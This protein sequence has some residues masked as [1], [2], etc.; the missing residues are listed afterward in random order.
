M[1]VRFIAD[2]LDMEMDYSAQQVDYEEVDLEQADPE[3]QRWV[4]HSLNKEMTQIREYGQHTYI[5]ITRGAKTPAAMRSRST[6]F[7]TTVANLPYRSLL[8]IRRKIPR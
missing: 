6:A 4:E 7:M 2:I 1:P 5:L 8:Q 3:I